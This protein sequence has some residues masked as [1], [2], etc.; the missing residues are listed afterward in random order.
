MILVD[1]ELC[2][3]EQAMVWLRVRYGVSGPVFSSERL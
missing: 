2:T 1:G 3:L